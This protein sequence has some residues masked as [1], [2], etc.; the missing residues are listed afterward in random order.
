M[1]SSSVKTL[2]V[3]LTI[4]FSI[5]AAAPNASAAQQKSSRTEKT[6]R[7]SRGPREDKGVMGFIR[8]LLNRFTVSTQDGISPPIP[9]DRT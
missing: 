5:M 4:S 2:T 8:A 7:A 1:R 6:A 3:A 9:A